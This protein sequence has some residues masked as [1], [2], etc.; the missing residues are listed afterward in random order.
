MQTNETGTRRS[1]TERAAIFLMTLG[2]EGAAEVLRHMAAKDVQRVGAAM[3]Q[4]AKVSRE[5]VSQVLTTFAQHVENETSVGIGSDEYV[6]RVMFEALGEEKASGVIDRILVGRRSKGLEA[7]RWMEPRVIADMIRLEHPQIVAIV[8]AYLDADQ[9]AAVLAN[10]PEW[11]RAD[12]V[13]RVATLD[14]VQPTALTELDEIMEKQFSG[15]AGGAPSSLGGAKAAATILN[16]LDA[17][18]EGVV[19]EHIRKVDETL[20]GRIQDLMFV[21]ENL[22]DLDDRGMQELLR[23][24]QGEQLLLALKGADDALKQK[25]FR[26]MS[27]RAAEMLRDDLE[28]RGPV[29]LAAVEAA[30]KEILTVARRMADEGTLMLGGRGGQY[31]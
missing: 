30:Q 5:E 31:V 15:S 28:A 21:F 1:G 16:C 27:Q 17:G 6:R 7:L 8:L 12:A 10:L 11:L 4:L 25:V 26:N 2:E 18:L 3:A 13:M 23:Q 24:V 29:R 20:C 22:I 14:G 9:A 19:M